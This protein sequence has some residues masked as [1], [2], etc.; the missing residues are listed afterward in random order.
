MSNTIAAISNFTNSALF[1]NADGSAF[2]PCR[3]CEP[4]V[5]AINSSPLPTLPAPPKSQPSERCSVKGCIF[6]VSS[7]QQTLC[8]SH[9]LQILEGELFQSHQPTHLFLLRA[10]LVIPDDEPDCSR[11]EDRHR[12]AMERE[13]F[14]A[15]EAA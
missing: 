11:Q 12:Q 4:E 8:R 5:A 2:Q 3:V 10:P 13:A 7:P 9:E 15:E 1:T 14:L 6:P